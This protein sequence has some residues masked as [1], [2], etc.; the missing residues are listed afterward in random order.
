MFEIEGDAFKWR[1]NTIFVGYKI[2]AEIL[3]KH[4]IMPLISVSHLVFTSPNAVS[5]LPGDDLDKVMPLVMPQPRHLFDVCDM[6][7]GYRQSRSYGAQ[8]GRHAYQKC[9]VQATTGDDSSPHD[10]RF[11]LHFG[12]TWVILDSCRIVSSRDGFVLAKVMTSN[13]EASLQVRKFSPEAKGSRQSRQSSKSRTSSDV[14]DRDSFITLI[15]YSIEGRHPHSR[16][17]KS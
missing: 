9:T 2:S 10:C 8:D 17:F 11:Q 15:P 7:Q 13:E 3:S 6:L 5:N 12:P 4:L 1:W 16:Q 14:G